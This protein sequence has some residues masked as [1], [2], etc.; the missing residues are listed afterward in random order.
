MVVVITGASRGI[1]RAIAEKLA[2]QGCDL[3]LAARSGESLTSVHSGL[4]KEYPKCTLFAQSFD[5]TNRA[6][7]DDFASKVLAFFGRVDVLIH[8][9]GVFKPGS[10]LDETPETYDLVMRTN[11]DGPYFLTKALLPHMIEA[12]SGHVINMCSVSSIQAFRNGGS[13]SISKHALHGFGKTLR[14]E[15]RQYGIR[16]TNILPGATWTD[17]WAGVDL[18]Q[19]RLMNAHNIA[20][21]VATAIQL[22]PNA[23]MEEVIIRP[24]LGDLP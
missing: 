9:A 20:E 2:S 10:L 13:Y 24:V 11:I 15:V 3:A 12:R 17:S 16:V 7:V 22:D 6:D 14:E 4:R 1:G 23:V 5:L 8:N 18:P 19:N 21:V